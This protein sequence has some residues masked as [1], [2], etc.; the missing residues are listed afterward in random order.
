VEGE[1]GE[2]E[3]DNDEDDEEDEEGEEDEDDQIRDGYDAEGN[4]YVTLEQSAK[5]ILIITG[6]LVGKMENRQQRKQNQKP[7][8]KRFQISRRMKKW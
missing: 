8:P 2:E 1:E 5:N 3:E 7:R 6:N 4:R